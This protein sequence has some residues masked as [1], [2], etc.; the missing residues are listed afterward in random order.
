[1]KRLAVILVLALSGC[2]YQ[3]VNQNDIQTAINACGSLENIESID[4]NFLGIEDALCTN[5][6]VI[7]LNSAVW[8]KK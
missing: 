2:M 8:I 1:M 5:R 4:A 3:S 7:R 6:K